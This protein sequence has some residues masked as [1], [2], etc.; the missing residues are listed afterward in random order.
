[1][2]GPRE[3]VESLT[4]FVV[5]DVDISSAIAQ[6]IESRE[7][8]L[9]EGV[10]AGVET[11]FITVT[12]TPQDGWRVLRVVPVFR[13]V[14]DELELAPGLYF[15]EVRLA[16]PEPD[17]ARLGIDDVVARV[18][19]AEAPPRFSRHEPEVSVPEGIEVVSVAPLWVQLVDPQ[20]VEQE[21]EDEVTDGEE[22]DEAGEPDEGDE[23]AQ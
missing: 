23:A 11:V 22:G 10:T 5:E 21:P 2:T 4:V 9:P 1:M 19:L 3:I 8:D 20:A 13:D 16:G 7:L 15:V 18:S 14:P 12:I 17:L 6:V